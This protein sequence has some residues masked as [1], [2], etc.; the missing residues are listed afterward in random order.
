[1]RTKSELISSIITIVL[2]VALEFL[3]IFLASK[4]GVVQRFSVLGA[5]NSIQTSIWERKTQMLRY[6]DLKQ[7]NE[8][9]FSENLELRQR[10][11]ELKSLL[12]SQEETN[13]T[14]SPGFTYRKATVIKNFIDR[15]HNYLVINKGSEDGIERGMGVV[16]KNGAIG[17]VN[18]TSAHYAYVVSLLNVGQSVSARIVSTGEFGPMSWSGTSMRKAS[19]R[20]IPVYSTAA[21]G[22]TVVTSGFSSVYPPDIPVGVVEASTLTN[23]T[24]LTL[25][26]RLFTNFHAL[27]NV[28]VVSNNR[29]DEINGLIEGN[30]Q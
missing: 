14:I 10:N 2:F 15:Q 25:D 12:L 26:I 13:D 24:S 17:I 16:T 1:M 20:E 28:Y 5:F 18:R 23:G 21:A 19:L 11:E 27:D 9:L 4:R 7:E 8:S 29:A 3:S 6:M 22:D 30:E